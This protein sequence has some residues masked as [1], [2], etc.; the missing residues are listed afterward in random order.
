VTAFG[1]ASRNEATTQVADFLR[2]APP[3]AQAQ[4]Q[5]TGQLPAPW[6]D[7]ILAHGI[8]TSF[9]L[10]VAFAALAFVVAL[11]VIRPKPSDQEAVE[12]PAAPGAGGS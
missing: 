3:E 6:A 7:Q 12:A 10:A 4:F 11:V 1:T 8:S 2:T 5:Q 9:Q